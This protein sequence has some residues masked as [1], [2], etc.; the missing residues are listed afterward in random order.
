MKMLFNYHTHTKRCGHAVGEDEDYVLAAIKGG[1]KTLGFSDH[2]PYLNKEG[3]GVH[4]PFSLIDDYINSINNLKIKYKNDIDIKVGFEVEYMYNDDYLKWL[5]SKVDYLILGQHNS[6][7]EYKN[8]DAFRYCDNKQILNY[9]KSVC[10][11]IDTGLFTYI[12]HPDV[13]LVKQESINDSIKEVA[14]MIAKKASEKKIPLEINV[15]GLYRKRKYKDKEKIFYP[16]HDFWK[17]LANYDIQAVVG[18]DAHDPNNL[19]DYAVID[20][21]LKQIQDLN[22]DII[23]KPFIK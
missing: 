13:I 7:M 16:N 9:G 3:D 2:G 1:Y 4:I 22:L 14:H 12:A 23:D 21:A 5:R 17:I 15:H 10:D 6:D 20:E 11:A 18:I 8:F 19:I